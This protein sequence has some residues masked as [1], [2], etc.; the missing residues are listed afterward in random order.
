MIFRDYWLHIYSVVLSIMVFLFVYDK[1]MVG[2]TIMNNDP[3]FNIIKVSLWGNGTAVVDRDTYEE[4]KQ[5]AIILFPAKC[6][7]SI[8]CHPEL[9]KAWKCNIIQQLSFNA[10]C[11]YE[12]TMLPITVP[13]TTLKGTSAAMYYPHPELRSMGD[14]D[15][16]TRR[17]DLETACEQLIENG[18]RVVKELNREIT[19]VKNGIVVE[20]HRRFAT[21]ND[22]E[23]AKYLDDLI[24]ENI[25]PSHV[26]PDLVNGLVLL[27]HIDQH[28]E[29][30][31]GLRQI[32]DWMM[33]VDKCLPDEK[34]P[35][36]LAIAEK[37]G[38][39]KLA[40]VCTRMCEM[41]LGLPRR[42]WCADADTALCAQLMDYVMAC[43]NFGH[44]KTSD[45][46]VIEDAIAYAST[47]KMFF[48]LLQ[49]QGLKNWKAAK[50]HKI[51]RPFA[52]VYQGF[53]Y[54]SKGMKRDRALSKLKE[55]YTAARKRNKMF[56]ALGVKTMAKGNVVYRDGKYIR[57]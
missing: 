24:I 46:A 51:L 2:V 39:E 50:D 30:G 55:E 1:S 29:G 33:F 36:F 56:D 37:V 52:W 19:L 10:Q 13:Y 54:I 18:Y 32:I 35:E 21:L 16:M 3:L 49:K 34:W 25:T 12:Q 9:K 26:L 23:Q 20:L 27:E 22:P 42:A 48:S 28:M 45:E 4:M 31:I 14:I 11:K 15:I 43:G 7:I 5:H 6:L 57:E 38:L 53:R 40:I 41:Y 47:P 8:E 17:E 44:K